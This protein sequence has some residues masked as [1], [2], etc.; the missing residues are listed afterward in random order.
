MKF[1]YNAR[2][3]VDISSDFG[4]VGNCVFRYSEGI[5]PILYIGV[6]ELH[7]GHSWIIRN[8]NFKD[9]ASPGD[10]IAEHAIHVWNNAY[11]TIF[12]SQT[13]EDNDR[14]IGF[15]MVKI[16]GMPQSYRRTREALFDT[17]KY[18]TQITAILLPMSA[19]S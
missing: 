2:K 14:T 18:I 8:N 6:V 10:H 13:F 9:I 3:G 15:G 12:Q 7:V 17:I 1:I 5:G 19:L 11:K 4:L 16:T